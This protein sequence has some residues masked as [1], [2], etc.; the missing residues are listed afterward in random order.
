MA[1]GH[2]SGRSRHRA[3]SRR[4]SIRQ[5]LAV[6]WGLPDVA[7][8]GETVVATFDRDRLSEGLARLH[9]QGF[10][11]S[12]R[13]LDAAR[14]DLNGQLSRVG[15]PPELIA[16][17]AGR[18]ST[19]STVIVVVNAAARGDQVADLLGRAGATAVDIVRRGPDSDVA[20]PVLDLPADVA[21]VE[22]SA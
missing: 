11:P 6:G 19:R 10:G 20:E 17:L 18:E 9:G 2:W 21:T 16:R 4:N 1:E 12:A 5:P 3:N 13:V 14:G 15:L 22:F 8:R 7:V